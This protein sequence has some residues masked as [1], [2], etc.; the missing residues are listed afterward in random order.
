MSSLDIE[1]SLVISRRVLE[2]VGLGHGL[3]DALVITRGHVLISHLLLESMNLLNEEVGDL[4]Q[5]AED[6]VAAPVEGEAAILL[7]QTHVAELTVSRVTEVTFLVANADSVD[8]VLGL[9][10]LSEDPVVTARRVQSSRDDL[11]GEL[12]RRMKFTGLVVTPSDRTPFRE[13]GLLHS[14]KKLLLGRPTAVHLLLIVVSIEESLITKHSNVRRLR[15]TPSGVTNE[16]LGVLGP[17]HTADEGRS[18][19]REEMFRGL[20]VESLLNRVDARNIAVEVPVSRSGI[21]S[22]GTVISDLGVEDRRFNVF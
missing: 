21:T 14:I 10:K 22:K 4:R 18:E 3:V 16:L 13:R 9:I 8:V 19:A 11:T 15:M 20:I 5:L 7:A 1:D 17:A 2:I 12:R 6:V